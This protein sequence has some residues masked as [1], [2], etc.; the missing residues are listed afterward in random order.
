M[1]TMSDPNYVDVERTDERYRAPCESDKF[2]AE[3]DGGACKS[4]DSS[5]NDSGASV[6]TTSTVTS[7]E[8]RR[9]NDDDIKMTSSS[10]DEHIVRS[11]ASSKGK[12]IY[13][14]WAFCVFRKL[15]I[16]DI[17]DQYLFRNTY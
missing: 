14:L 2:S 15:T 13:V 7:D 11:P 12:Q 8:E 17:T 3:M 10:E 4:A 6:D 16:I 1:H 5:L 9:H